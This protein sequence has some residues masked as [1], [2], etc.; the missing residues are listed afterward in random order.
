MSFIREI[1]WPSAL[2]VLKARVSSLPV[3]TV[4]V[5][6]WVAILVQVHVVCVSVCS[7]VFSD[8]QVFAPSTCSCFAGLVGCSKLALIEKS[9]GIVVERTRKAWEYSGRSRRGLEGA[10]EQ[11]LSPGCSC[12]GV[13]GWNLPESNEQASGA[14]EDERPLEKSQGKQRCAP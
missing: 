2:L 1:H 8:G 12:C 3:G 14:R 10:E 9:S 7:I 6:G 5:Q 4:R 13:G 11:A